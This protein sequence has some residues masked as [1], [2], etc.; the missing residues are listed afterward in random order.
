MYAD[1]SEE[2]VVPN[3]EV[4]R[5]SVSWTGRHGDRVGQGTQ[6]AQQ[7]KSKSKDEENEILKT[8]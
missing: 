5:Y 8:S 4:D 2:A 7:G 3:S 1:V 6:L